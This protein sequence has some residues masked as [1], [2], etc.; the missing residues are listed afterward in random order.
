MAFSALP[1]KHLFLEKRKAQDCKGAAVDH[2]AGRIS[3][4]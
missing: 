2:R 3:W 4:K 1:G